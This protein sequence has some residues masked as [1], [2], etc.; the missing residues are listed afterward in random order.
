VTL[1][2]C[3]NNYGPYQHA[4]KMIP[5]II[6]AGL[7]KKPIPVY[8]DGSNIRDW[9][10]VQDHCE[11]IDLIVRQG[12]LGESYN[13]GGNHEMS[14]LALV[15]FICDK[16]SQLS[17]NNF[18]YYSLITFVTD[19]V[20]HDWR[21]AINCEKIKKELGWQSKRDFSCGIEDL[22]HNIQNESL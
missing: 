16:L 6:R 18:N 22:L 7:E 4:E 10:H 9:L 5:T 21:Y 3:S 14:N 13:V 11:A 1:S 12:Q 17:P 20:G 15:H 2:N 8:G 19:R